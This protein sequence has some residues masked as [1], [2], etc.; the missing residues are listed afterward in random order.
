MWSR[1]RGS[2][3]PSVTREGWWFLLATLVVA[4]VAVDTGANLFFLAF[5]ILVST[6][7]AG[8]VLAGSTLSR[9]RVRRVIPPAVF[10]GTPYL[11]GIALGN[12]KRRL[13]SFS[14]EVEDLVEGR[15]IE[16]RCYFLK[17]PAGRTQE[18]AYRNLSARRG[19]LTLTGF[20]LATKFPFGLFQRTRLVPDRADLIVYPA[21]GPPPPELARRL[22]GRPGPG[23]TRV[24][25]RQGELAG[26]RA[27]RP[28]DDPRDI[29]W[30]T[31][32]RRGVR[33]S[34]STKTMSRVT[35]SSCST[36]RP[37]R[38]P[39]RPP[40]N[41]RC[42][43]PRGFA[44]T[45]SS[46]GYR[47]GLATRARDRAERSGPGASAPDPARARA[48][49]PRGRAAAIA[50]LRAGGAHRAGLAGGGRLRG[51]RLPGPAR[52]PP[53]RWR[54]RMRFQLAH[55][56]VTYLLVLATMAALEAAGVLSLG[57]LALF[58]GAA[59]LS[60]AV[61][62][63]GPVAAALDRS[64]RGVR[65]V[66]LAV[67][68]ILLWR[69][70][71]GLADPDYGPGFDLGLALLAYK[72][73]HR[74]THRDYVQVLAFSFVLVLV[75]ATL[76]ASLLFVVAFAVYVGLAIW[77]LILFHLRRE[78]EENY[79]VKHSAQAP[80]QKVGVQRILG[81]RRVVGP[82]FFAATSLVAAAVCAGGLVVFVFVPRFGAGFVLGGGPLGASALATGEEMDDWTLRHGRG[83]A[84]PRG[85]AGDALEHGRAAR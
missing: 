21:L 66:V 52:C 20:R 33:S 68:A 28:G 75:A 35:P 39:T 8:F 62:P 15:P 13:P 64:A 59:A 48:G 32:A 69:V 65:V 63:G 80:S 74:R 76:A 45:S 44:S 72:L 9:L 85:L 41:G 14:I 25:G 55:K 53:A 27:F 47:V 29:H 37:K 82:A 36:T 6:A 78:M 11:M 12:Q 30:R 5:G 50:A 57:S 23:S 42:P 83:G 79:L 18:T 10:A 71:R 38:P 40:S 56:L 70:W 61:D 81:S 73:F 84:A 60:F 26:L 17:V 7:G 67:S 58:L 16:K 24:R 46:A 77:T 3:R 51:R 19:R 34:A 2:G 54:G 49:G 1:G 4:A 22:G 43:R 31:S